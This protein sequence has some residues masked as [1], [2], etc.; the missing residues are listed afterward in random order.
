MYTVIHLYIFTSSVSSY[1]KPGNGPF[2]L[3]NC[4]SLLTVH[5]YVVKIVEFE[6]RFSL[7]G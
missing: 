4:G 5:C 7:I 3:K 6:G 1:K 2:E